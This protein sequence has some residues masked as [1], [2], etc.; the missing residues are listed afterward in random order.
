MKHLFKFSFVSFLVLLTSVN[1]F[2]NA[3]VDLLKE[4][5]GIANSELI[6]S[7]E[8]LA[9]KNTSLSKTDVNR[10]KTGLRKWYKDRFHFTLED[11]NPRQNMQ[12]EEWT[13]EMVDAHEKTIS[14]FESAQK[15]VKDEEL[16]TMIT[17]TLPTLRSHLDMMKGLQAKMK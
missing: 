1:A 15:D 4:K 5:L 2:A 7:L 9:Q 10:I 8:I 3:G 12:V 17:N 6:S 14:R 13:D 16:R 11:H